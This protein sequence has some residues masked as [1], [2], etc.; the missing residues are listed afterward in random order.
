MCPVRPTGYP[1]GMPIVNRIRDFLS[2]PQGRRLTETGRR[3]A[4]D[5]RNRERA[6]GMLARL[7]RR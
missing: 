4:A 2:S 6:R 1:T 7:R 5:P 3:A